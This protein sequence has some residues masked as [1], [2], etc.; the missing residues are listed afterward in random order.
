MP[1]KVQSSLINFR[2]MTATVMNM[3]CRYSK[4]NLKSLTMLSCSK[5]KIQSSH[6]EKNVKKKKVN[7]RVT[8]RL[9]F[10]IKWCLT[11][12]YVITDFK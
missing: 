2:V 8:D 5:I 6:I 3:V 10:R 12:F 11:F 7:Y 4:T 9:R 1:I